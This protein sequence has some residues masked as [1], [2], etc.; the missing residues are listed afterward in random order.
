MQLI[1]EIPDVLET[2]L[3]SV[4]HDIEPDDPG[5]L[6]PFLYKLAGDILNGM[7]TECEGVEAFFN[8]ELI[9]QARHTLNCIFNELCSCSASSF[10]IIDRDSVVVTLH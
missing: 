2:F 7:L 4:K 10:Q 1:V 9:E 8:D 6:D 5:A 3:W